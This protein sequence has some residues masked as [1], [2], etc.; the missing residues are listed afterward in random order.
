MT[1]IDHGRLVVSGTVDELATSGARRLVV[2]IEGDRT[3]DWARQLPG[4]TVSEVERWCRA[5]GPGELGRQ[6]RRPPCR[7]ASGAGHPVLLRASPSVRGVPGGAG[8]KFLYIILIAAV[9]VALRVWVFRRR[10][11]R[12][13]AQDLAGASAGAIGS[14]S[15]R[16]RPHPRRKPRP[17]LARPRGLFRRRRDG[18]KPRDHRARPGPHLPGRHA[19]HPDR[20]RR[21]HRHPDPP[22]RR[23]AHHPDGRGRR[24]PVARDRAVRA[25]RRVK[26]PGLRQ[27]RA[28]ALP[29]SSQGRPALREGRFRHR[30]RQ[31]DPAQ[32]ARELEPAPRPTPPSSRTWPNTSAC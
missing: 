17:E 2:R 22:Q 29:R 11:S 32:P 16:A 28:G 23:G 24:R 15:T 7:D 25:C 13:A 5:P 21:R 8:V 12:R 27:T 6:R 14:V 31:P 18:R 3:G 1:I 20:R 9:V 4:V 30:R 26:E 19:H 10:R